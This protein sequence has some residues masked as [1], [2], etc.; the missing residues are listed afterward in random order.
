[1]LFLLS[2]FNSFFAW[3]KRIGQLRGKYRQMFEFIALVI[4]VLLN[5]INLCFICFVFLKREHASVVSF[6]VQE[7]SQI[8]VIKKLSK[9]SG[10]S[11]KMLHLGAKLRFDRFQDYLINFD[12]IFLQLASY[13]LLLLIDT[14]FHHMYPLSPCLRLLPGHEHLTQIMSHLVNVT[15]IAFKRHHLVKALNTFSYFNIALFQVHY[16]LWKLLYS[17]QVFIS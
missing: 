2:Y 12:F 3:L 6:L 11:L 7:L 17:G 16:C 1:M 13:P 8:F 9:T 4:Y 14:L 15:F 5:F 10:N